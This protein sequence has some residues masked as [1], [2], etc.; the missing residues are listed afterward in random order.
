M[1]LRNFLLPYFLPYRLSRN[2][3]IES[4]VVVVVSG[5]YSP[6]IVLVTCLVRTV[7]N[8]KGPFPTKGPYGKT[9]NRSL[10]TFSRTTSGPIVSGQPCECLDIGDTMLD[11][12]LI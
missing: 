1:R 5:R 3:G 11:P 6:T 4:H 8:Q 10:E 2:K 12:K 7:P 9:Q